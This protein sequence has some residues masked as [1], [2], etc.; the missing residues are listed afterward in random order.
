MRPGQKIVLKYKA[1][2]MTTEAGRILTK[3]ATFPLYHRGHRREP[4]GFATGKHL[5]LLG[6][7]TGKK[8]TAGVPKGQPQGRGR[9]VSRSCRVVGWGGGGGVGGG[10]GRTSGKVVY[11]TSRASSW[12]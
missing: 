9:A 4:T 11:T 10:G 1:I 5:V 3:K 6:E 7:M 8:N 2:Q 12:P